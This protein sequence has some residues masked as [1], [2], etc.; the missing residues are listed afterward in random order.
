MKT[1]SL[2]L[3]TPK[4]ADAEEAR[5]YQVIQKWSRDLGKALEAFPFEY[6]KSV[7]LTIKQAAFPYRI[8][9]A[10]KAPPKHLIITYLRNLSDD[11]SPPGAVFPDW[12]PEGEGVNLR[13]ITGLTPGKT[14]TVRFL[15]MG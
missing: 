4:V 6:M 2:N 8:N 3:Y 14:Y 13:Y 9:L 12:I 10:G 11:V 1:P 5:T 7:D 15:I